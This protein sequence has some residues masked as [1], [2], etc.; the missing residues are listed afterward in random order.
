VRTPRLSVVGVN[1]R[2]WE[3]TAALTRQVRGSAAFRRGLVEVVIVDNHSPAHPVASRLRR[4]PGVSLRRWRR[5]RGFARAVNEGVRLSRG[6]WVLL[7]NPDVS[8]GADFLEGLLALSDR[9]VAEDR[10]A[11]IVGF[12]LHN[13]DG[14]PQHSAGPFPTLAGTLARLLRPRAR[15]KYDSPRTDRP[16]RVPWVTGCCLLLLRD[17]LEQLG[18]FDEDFFLYYEDVDL[19]RRARRRGW[20][21]RYEPG[22]HAVHY[23]PLHGRAVTAPLQVCTRHALLTYAA[24]HWPRWQV[25]L[26]AGLVRLEAWLRRRWALARGEDE[27]AAH[28]GELGAMARDLAAGGRAA[29][30]RRLERVV[31]RDERRAFGVTPV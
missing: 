22:L 4:W 19:C 25:G 26:L 20:A 14:S 29:A 3:E 21:V 24:K 28:F 27:R 5:N 10:R 31:R 11:G 7:L 30:R 23:R 16:S 13:G 18:G 6:P 2:Q 17:C 8:L 12:Q 9:L 1:Y 15:R